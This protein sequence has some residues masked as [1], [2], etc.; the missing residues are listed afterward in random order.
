MLELNLDL[1]K[2]IKYF[3]EY[4]DSELKRIIN[5]KENSVES[6][7]AKQHIIKENEIGEHMYIIL[8]G[9][10]DVYVKGAYSKAESHIT[11]LGEGD[12]FGENA[13]LTKEVT[14]RSASVRTTLPTTVFKI[15][16]DYVYF[17]RKADRDIE[18]EGRYPAHEVRDMIGKIPLFRGLTQ[19]EFH[20][21]DEWTTIIN[22][23]QSEY[24]YRH[25][26]PAE[27][28]YVVLE[29]VVDLLQRGSSGNP[30]GI[31]GVYEVGEYFGEDALLDPKVK[32]KRHNNF[33]RAK[34]DSRLIE[35]PR[36]I[37]KLLM[38]RDKTL[39][40]YLKK[41]EVV[42]KMKRANESK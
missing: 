39:I 1:L 19:D 9:H 41:I 4:D 20:N 6:F 15:H 24:I 3:S 23:K 12:Y 42:K 34:V 35:I 28:M 31:P 22:V 25:G 16:K 7:E 17:E 33:A 37:F 30:Y 29:G 27:Y 21:V 32:D 13:A 5:A 18:F 8:E 11:A 36:K 40:D 2:K 10:V 38:D 26:D 14:R